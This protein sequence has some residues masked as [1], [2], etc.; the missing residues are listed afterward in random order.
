MNEQQGIAIAAVLG[1]CLIVAI[2]ALA[3]VTLA[4]ALM[5]YR[6]FNQT[7]SQMV[8]DLAGRVI[9]AW[10]SG[11]DT[12]RDMVRDI[13]SETKIE[14]ETRI[15]RQQFRPKAESLRDAMQADE[16]VTV[17]TFGQA[18]MMPEMMGD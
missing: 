8:D 5:V 9:A 15:R 1:A 4:M 7:E 3:A 10:Q 17:A 13:E 12:R 6:R 11:S 18:P 14:A 2:L 16:P